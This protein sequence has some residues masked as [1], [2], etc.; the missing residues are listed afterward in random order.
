M[1][2]ELA[3]AIAAAVFDT[4]EA[5]ALRHKSISLSA[6]EDAVEG[7]LAREGAGTAHIPTHTITI[8]PK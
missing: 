6:V 1:A 8:N 5:A 2:R 3:Q 7:V 4:I